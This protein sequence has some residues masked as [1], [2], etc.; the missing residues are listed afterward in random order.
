M[1]VS[2]FSNLICPDCREGIKTFKQKFRCPSCN[3]PIGLRYGI[4]VF[5]EESG[6]SFGGE[7]IKKWETFYVD[8]QRRFSK[9]LLE[10][11]RADA[12][13]AKRQ[14]MDYFKPRNGEC[15]LELG[16]G[17][18]FS[19]QEYAKEGMRVTGIDF[20]LSAVKGAKKMFKAQGIKDYLLVCGDVQKMPFK[21]NSFDLI[22]GGGVI[23]HIR[24]PLLVIQEIYRVLKPGGIVFNTVPL[25]NLGSLTY[26]QIWGNIPYFPVLKEL[27]EAVHVKI[28]RCRHMTFGWEYS[29]TANF[30]KKIHQKI[31]FKETVI[32]KF[33]V[34]LEF[35][36]IKNKRIKEI[37]I[38]LAQNSPWFWPM[39][40][41]VARK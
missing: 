7:T 30:L 17:W 34:D 41:V 1:K 19:C 9:F 31:G 21:E 28:L 4:P 33:E 39:V 27:A 15:F 5:V 22:Y 12:R 2:N 16:C 29:F 25:L 3:R 38:Y 8:Y 20:S 24:E 10:R 6:S 26:R 11:E 37:L 14:I 36:F 18:G 23:E 35:A 13:N 32:K 40:Y